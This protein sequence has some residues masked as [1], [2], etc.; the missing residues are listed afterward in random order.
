MD[1]PNGPREII[2]N[3]ETGLL[4]KNG[5]VEDLATQIEWLIT[6]EQERKEMGHN[7]R[8]SAAHRKMSVV[9]KEWEDLYTT[10]VK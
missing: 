9:M 3:G 5:D 6:H 1:C 7:A 8:L 10:V 4:A 2:K